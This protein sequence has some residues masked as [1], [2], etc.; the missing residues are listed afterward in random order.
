MKKVFAA[1]ILF[2]QFTSAQSLYNHA[3][4]DSASHAHRWYK[5]TTFHTV[6]APVSLVAFGVANMGNRELPISSG[7]VQRWRQR[8][9]PR[10]TTDID[11]YM[12][13]A[14]LVV[15]F[16]LDAAGVESQHNWVNQAIIF[17][18]A[19]ALNGY[20]TKQLKLKTDVLRPDGS[21]RLSF[22]SAHTSSA[23]VAAEMLHQ[24]FKDKS[25][26]ISIAGYSLASAVGAL[27]I[28]NNKHW[29]SDV[30]AGAGIGI[31]SVRLTYLAYPIIHRKICQLRPRARKGV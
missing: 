14:S 10:F 22:P 3:A 13:S 5:T 17:G 15:M 7:D 2:A 1:L 20:A 9:F 26:W 31:L 21:D 6:L 8:E 25:V 24:E 11:D 19:N 18:L 29:L 30:A 27:R 12:P 23:F 28:M 4:G 16:S